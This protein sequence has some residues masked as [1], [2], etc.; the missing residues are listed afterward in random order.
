MRP[1]K[2][3]E[4][5]GKG[6]ADE[7]TIPANARP[8]VKPRNKTAQ[9]K[10]APT[11]KLASTTDSKA[12][13]L[14]ATKH[15]SSPASHQAT[16][17]VVKQ[18]SQ[19]LATSQVKQVTSQANEPD[20]QQ[21]KIQAPIPPSHKSSN[22][23]LYPHRYIPE[24]RKTARRKGPSVVYLRL[25]ADQKKALAKL[26]SAYNDIE[27]VN[28]SETE[29]AKIGLAALMLDYKTNKTRSFLEKVLK[30]MYEWD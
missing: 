5:F 28:T 13:S 25:S 18:P 22:P 9:S 20:G 10:A 14:L 17:P 19:P 11:V 27:D 15:D 12:D 6:Q 7:I 24:I 26:V 2:N 29:I 21:P 3:V 30:S 16:V 23:P 4:N 1:I 8:I